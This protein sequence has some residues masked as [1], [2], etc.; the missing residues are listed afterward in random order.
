MPPSCCCV[1]LLLLAASVSAHTQPIP[2]PPA[3]PSPSWSVT[4]CA[5]PKA[6]Y[7]SQNDLCHDW[8]RP[9]ARVKSW[10]HRPNLS[11][12]SGPNS[13]PWEMV[14][15][16]NSVLSLTSSVHHIETFSKASIVKTSGGKQEPQWITHSISFSYL[17]GSQVPGK[18]FVCLCSSQFH[19]IP[20]LQKPIDASVGRK[21]LHYFRTQLFETYWM[22][23]HW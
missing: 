12:A 20:Q 7:S 2:L 21:S 17:W 13:H 6:L 15:F 3:L 16:P 5:W 11:L 19:E 1:I 23:I 22:Q 9:H 4:W 8:P 10:R 14:P 18:S